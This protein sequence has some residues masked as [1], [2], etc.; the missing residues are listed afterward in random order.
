MNERLRQIRLSLGGSQAKASLKE[1]FG[2]AQQYLWANY[3]T[4]K[5]LLSLMRL[6]RQ[7]ANMGVLI[8]IGL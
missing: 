1:R 4:G 8:F 6:S 7:L 2:I 5:R 3:E